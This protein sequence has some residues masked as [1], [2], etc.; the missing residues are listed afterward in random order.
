MAHPGEGWCQICWIL[1]SMIFG[2]PRWGFRSHLF[3]SSAFVNKLGFKHDMAQL[4]C[5]LVRQ[6]PALDVN[7][8]NSAEAWR[9][10]RSNSD[11]YFILCE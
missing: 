7:S 10:W 2:S 3:L 6:P 9:R 5:I 1:L 4:T 8:P 11:T